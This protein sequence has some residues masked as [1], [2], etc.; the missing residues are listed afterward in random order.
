[1]TCSR[2]KTHFHPVRL[3]VPM[4]SFVYTISV[5]C[6][7]PIAKTIV[8]SS[9]VSIFRPTVIKTCYLELDI[10]FIQVHDQLLSDD[11]YEL[12]YS[13]S[14]IQIYLLKTVGTVFLCQSKTMPYVFG[15]SITRVTKMLCLG[16]FV[17]SS[18][19]PF[20]AWWLCFNTS[21]DR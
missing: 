19:G 16:A 17:G 5:Q 11:V 13:W 14:Q 1:M 12:E 15:P 20:W 6:G 2:V 18:R 3:S 9:A 4:N 10:L 21:M 7:F 8:E